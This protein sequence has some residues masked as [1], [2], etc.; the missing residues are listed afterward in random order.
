MAQSFD[1]RCSFNRGA[2][3]RRSVN[4]I[5]SMRDKIATGR[6]SLAPPT[7]LSQ[8]TARSQATPL[9]ATATEATLNWR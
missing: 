3:S 4:N 1:P 8:V 2:T 6:R 5:T 9:S 7:T